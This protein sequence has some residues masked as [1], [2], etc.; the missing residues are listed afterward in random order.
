MSTASDSFDIEIA[1]TSR[2]NEVDFEN[3]SFGEIFSDHML[4]CD[5]KNGAWER[6]QI[7]PYQNISIS[8]HR[9]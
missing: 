4:V 3:L 2:I 5:Y 8:R 7:K 6:P 1:K 9:P